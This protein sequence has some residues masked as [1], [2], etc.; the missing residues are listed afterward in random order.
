VST[1]TNSEPTSADDDQ[2]VDD[3]LFL[4]VAEA[5]VLLRISRRHLYDLVAEGTVRSVRFGRKVVI[6]RAALEELAAT[7]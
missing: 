4:T 2:A 5:A 3:S 1:R 7:A 6:P